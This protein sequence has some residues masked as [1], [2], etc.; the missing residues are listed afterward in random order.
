MGPPSSGFWFCVFLELEVL[1][2]TII[3]SRASSHQ[4]LFDARSKSPQTKETCIRC[5]CTWVLHYIIWLTISPIKRILLIFFNYYYFDDLIIEGI[6]QLRYKTLDNTHPFWL[7]YLLNFY[8]VI[9]LPKYAGLLR[10][11]STHKLWSLCLLHIVWCF[12]S[13]TTRIC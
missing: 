10:E 6:N 12:K 9:Q 1:N 7:R 3:Q 13:S 8:L 4:Q 2:I 5:S 11:A